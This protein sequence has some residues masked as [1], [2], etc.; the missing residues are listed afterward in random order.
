MSRTRNVNGVNV[1]FTQQEED[2]ADIVDN[3][4]ADGA[5]DRAKEKAITAIDI[6]RDQKKEL[7]I[8]TEGFEIDAGIEAAGILAVKEFKA[9]GEAVPIDTLTFSGGVATATTIQNHHQKDGATLAMS[10]AGE[11]EFNITVVITRINAK[12]FSYPVAGNPSSPASGN[13]VF[14]IASQRIITADNQIVFVSKT[15]HTE[16]FEAVIEYNDGGDIHARMLKNAILACTTITEIDAIDITA[17][18]PDTGI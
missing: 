4:H 1:P 14:A 10:G 6:L 2:A 18:W 17:G 16:I 5:L 7:P 11:A 9:G 15:V 13:P 3:V 12:K 8:L